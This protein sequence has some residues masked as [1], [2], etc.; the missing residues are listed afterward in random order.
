MRK[1]FGKEWLSTYNTG[2]KAYVA[3]DWKTGLEYFNK[4][5]EM[6]PDDKPTKNILAFMSETDNKPPQGWKGYKFFNE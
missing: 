1:P 4:I 2:F 6:K 3:G 5:L